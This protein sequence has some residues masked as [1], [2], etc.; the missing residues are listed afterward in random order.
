M[1]LKMEAEL[2]LEDLG[3]SSY[4]SIKLIKVGILKQEML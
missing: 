3:A 1:N 4:G 2:K